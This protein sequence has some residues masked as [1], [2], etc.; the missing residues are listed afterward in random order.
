[1]HQATLEKNS[2]KLHAQIK[3]HYVVLHKEKQ[4][5]HFLIHQPWQKYILLLLPP[6]LQPLINAHGLLDQLIMLQPSNL[7]KELVL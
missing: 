3:V 4:V 2:L 6:H 7:Q 1:M 5:I